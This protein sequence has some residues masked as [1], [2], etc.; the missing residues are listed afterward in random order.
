MYQF[1]V[2]REL[3]GEY[4]EDQSLKTF[5]KPDEVTGFVKDIGDTF[6]VNVSVSKS[7]GEDLEYFNAKD[8]V[9]KGEAIYRK[10]IDLGL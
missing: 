9:D 6:V 8:W 4:T 2:S 3:R 5:D 10:L 7:G 1:V